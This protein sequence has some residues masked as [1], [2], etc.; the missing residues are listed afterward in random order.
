MRENLNNYRHTKR[1]VSISGQS[2]IEI[3]L[4]VAVFMV[5]VVTIGYLMFDSQTSLRQSI[6][7]T[8]ATLL[9]REGIE[10]VRGIGLNDFDAIPPGTYGLA[11]SGG[12]WTLS[13]TQ[14]STGKFTRSITISDVDIETKQTVS[15]V[16]WNT[17]DVRENTVSLTEY[18]TDWRGTKG[19]SKYLDVTIDLALLIA[20]ST[21]LSW[22]TLENTGV[23]DVTLAGMII[24]WDGEA[25]VHT[26]TLS[27]T[28]IFSVATTSGGVS[29]AFIDTT[30]YL[31]SPS[32]GI[33]VFDEI[34]FTD[35]VVGTDFTLSFILGDG[36]RKHV[37]VSL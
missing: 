29:G 22:I 27:G 37:L 5:G 9:S 12:V 31:L 35:S 1:C 32:D 36:S 13:S 34:A 23:T 14:D 11:Q 4:A 10:A 7:M 19:D 21:A 18:I 30:D 33:K 3:L 2:L 25:K 26:I 17:S 15:S 24:A 20:S 8:Q 28:D 16:S 6:E